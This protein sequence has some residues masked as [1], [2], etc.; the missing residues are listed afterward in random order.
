MPTSGKQ[1]INDLHKK[2]RHVSESIICTVAKHYNWQLTNKFIQSESCALAKSCQ[3]NTNKEIK[4]CSERP[5][6]CFFVDISSMKDKSFGGSKFWLL[7]V[8]D[9]TNFGF[10]FFLKL[11]D[12]TAEMMIS[13]I[14][15]LHNEEKKISNATILERMLPSKLKQ[16]AKA[17]GSISSSV[18]GRCHSKMDEW[19]TCLL[20][21][22][23]GSGKC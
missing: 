15:R 23:E 2:L 10:S 18:H 16:S 6:E 7:A 5:R 8:D 22:L 21:Y 12:Q 11:K 1:N 17:L 9:V 19:R 13:L 3:K 4:A 20:H 14:K